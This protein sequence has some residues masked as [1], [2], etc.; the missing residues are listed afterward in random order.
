MM[1]RAVVGALA[2]LLISGCGSLP[3]LPER[4]TSPALTPHSDSALV[5]TVQA[6]TPDPSM[7]GFRLMPIGFSS[8]DA[9]VELA[10][11][12][13]HSLD[14]QYYLI[15]NDRTGRLFMR[16]L[17][18]AALRGV[19]VRLLVDDLYTTGGDEMFRGLAA[20][21]NVEVRVFNPF[22][23]GRQ[24]L[25][26]K[27]MTSLVAFQRLNRRMHNKLFIADGVAAVMGGRN[28]ADEYFARSPTSNF[29][30]MDVLVVGGVMQ[31]L[32]SIF[33]AYWN[34]QQAY[35]VETIVA[36][37]G[38][39]VDLQRGFDHL[40]EDGE[41]MTSIPVPMIDMLGHRP[42]GRDLDA[43]H[44]PLVWGTAVA[45][46]DRPDK[47]TATTVEMARA[48]SA[49]MNIMDRV[50]TSE[51]NVVISSPY[52]VPGPTGVQAFRDLTRRDVKVAILTNSLAANDVPLVHTGYARY[53]VELLRTGVEL[54]E[55]SPTRMI[56]ND[57]LLIPTMSLGRLH[58]K[59]AV[60]DESTVYI[61]SVNLDPR[62]DSTN[63]ELGILAQCP[64]L[65]RQ[66]I[67]VIAASQR[68]SSYRLRFA[69]DG[70]SLEWLT[71]TD[72]GDVVL[73]QE[74]ETTPLMRLQNVLFGPFVP[75]QLL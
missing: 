14:V 33:D 74:P 11:R 48:M 24:S 18:D 29:V 31:R 45:F 43:G 75:E 12:A 60:I 8:L 54:Y 63:T 2:T 51:R 37:S 67:D 35:P 71:T 41:Q 34:S 17:R 27:F 30:D 69:S 9:R 52:F 32:R 50:S 28:I 73:T 56:R 61:G 70:V 36:A 53:R 46:A 26:T 7:T 13:V 62:S 57:E 58:T 4:Q 6:S 72:A 15:A 59:A 66:V 64:E 42:L 49:Q 20:F 39:R 10:R 3:M 22:C 23:C 25:A 38:D 40:V 55:L 1:I 65:A 44:L 16:N 5:R 47:V 68:G 19:R 21:E